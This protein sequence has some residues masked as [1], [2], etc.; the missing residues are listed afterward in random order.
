MKR[1]LLMP[2]LLDLRRSAAAFVA[3]AMSA[4]L[5]VF[6]FIVSDS[7]RTRVTESARA[8]VGPGG[9]QGRRCRRQDLRAGRAAGLR[10]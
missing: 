2:A 5:I 6:A 4:A 7:V 3:V 8:S 1:G 10:G 9:P